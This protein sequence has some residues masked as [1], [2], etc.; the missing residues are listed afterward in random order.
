MQRHINGLSFH[1]AT[2]LPPDISSLVSVSSCDLPHLPVITTDALLPVP[3]CPVA[4]GLRHLLPNPLFFLCLL[5]VEGREG[6]GSNY[7]T[8]IDLFYALT[9]RPRLISPHPAQV[10]HGGQLEITDG[11]T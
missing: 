7:T 1:V 11:F 10:T 8:V 6:G 5:R 4:S 9:N 2:N 3:R